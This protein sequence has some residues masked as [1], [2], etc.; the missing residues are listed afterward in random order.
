MVSD[1]KSKALAKAGAAAP[2]FLAAAAFAGRRRGYM[3]TTGR[4]GTGCAAPLA[5]PRRCSVY[6]AAGAYAQLSG[7]LE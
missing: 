1:A 4:Q 5:L 2:P 6:R 7:L 3:F